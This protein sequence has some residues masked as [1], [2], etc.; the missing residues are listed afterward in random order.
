M[1]CIIVLFDEGEWVLVLVVVVEILYGICDVDWCKWDELASFEEFVRWAKSCAN[2]VV[3]FVVGV[4]CKVVELLE[5]EEI[6]MHNCCDIERA[7]GRNEV[8][9]EIEWR[10]K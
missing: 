10:V 1:K 9:D 7:L 4:L 8:L 2:Y 5:R 3:M 6:P